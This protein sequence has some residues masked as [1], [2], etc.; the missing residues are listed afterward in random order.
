MKSDRAQALTASIVP[1]TDVTSVKDCAPPGMGL[2]GHPPART[3]PHSECGEV[4]GTWWVLGAGV[5][6]HLSGN[7][8]G[9]VC[10]SRICSSGLSVPS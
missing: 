4:L 9:I 7:L 2:Q 1:V 10:D 5:T 8:K 3:Q 6:H